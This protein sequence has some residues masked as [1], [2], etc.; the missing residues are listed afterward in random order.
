MIFSTPELLLVGAVAAVGVLHT[1]VPDHWVPITLIARQRGWSITQTV[2]AALVAGTGH[3]LS[4]L[5]IAVVVW[6]AG[7]LA[8]QRFGH[9][10]DTLASFALIGFGAWI[11]ISALLDMCKPGGGHAHVHGHSHAHD[12][13]HTHG[14]DEL[15]TADGVPRPGDHGHGAHDHHRHAARPKTGSRT[16]LLL[17]LGSS[18]MVEGIPAFF[19]AGKYGAGLIAVMSLV[20]GAATI[21]TYVV[22]CAASVAGLQRVSLGPL[23]RYGEVLSGAFIA[24]IGVVFWAW[25]LH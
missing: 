4:T 8:A 22:L 1:I 9:L 25:P 24:L 16:A 18:P 6:G 2:R 14:L 17:I 11:A 19:A 7:A 12:H 21:A 3:V 5:V 10:V 15:V 23:E 20:F 13:D